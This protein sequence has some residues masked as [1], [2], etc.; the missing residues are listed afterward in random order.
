VTIPSLSARICKVFDLDPFATIASGALLL[1]VRPADAAAILEA[2]RKNGI[3]ASRIGE[4]VPGVGKVLSLAGNHPDPWPY[5][6][7]DEIGKVYE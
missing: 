6:D 3:A 4:I 1:A 5:P 7:R 2:Y